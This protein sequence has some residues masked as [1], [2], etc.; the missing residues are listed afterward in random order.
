MIPEKWLG[1]TY[2]S[3]NAW[4]REHYGEKCTKVSVDGGFTCPNRDGK[5]DTR[6]CIFCSGRGS[7]D[8][9]VP[10]RELDSWYGFCDEH[11]TVVYFQAYTNTYAEPEKLCGMF[12]AA[13]LQKGVIGIAIATRPDCLGS[14]ILKMLT[15]LKAECEQKKQFIWVEL[16]LQTMHETTAQY[17]R[18]HFQLSAY[19]QAIHSLTES[20][21]PYITHVIIGLPGESREQILETVRYVNHFE[22]AMPFGIK[23]QLLHVL[24]G[25]DLAADYWAGLFKVLEKEEYLSIL[26][27]CIAWTKP[28]VVLHR[29]TGDGPKKI[30]IAPKWSGNKKD[31][32]NSL[33]RKLKEDSIY[34]GKNYGK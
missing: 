17:I 22:E 27:D 33:H 31:V 25:T 10:Y 4:F 28:E 23:L 6:G 21:I 18:R 16:G 1:K 2:Y 9:A 20:G 29:V 15:E 30:L 3:L 13:L 14:D 26:A 34:Q 8:F 19:E 11:K 7:G 32:L 12:R 24:E 5:L